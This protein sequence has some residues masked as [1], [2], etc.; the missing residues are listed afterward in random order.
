M[1]QTVC[2]LVS[3]RDRQRLEAVTLD[4]NRQP[5]H[6]ERTQVVLA[7]VASVGGG[8]V[9]QPALQFGVSRPMVWR[10]QQR[11]AEDGVNGLLCDKTRKPPI[12]AHVVVVRLTKVKQDF[13]LPV[14]C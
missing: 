8:P 11:F 10:W 5:Q 7:S 13:M 2:V 12:V 9:Q 3:T 6:I 4:R 14:T 1:T